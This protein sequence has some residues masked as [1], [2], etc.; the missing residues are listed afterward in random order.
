MEKKSR[1]VPPGLSY[2]ADN[3]INKHNIL[4]ASKEEGSRW[5]KGL[6][7]PKQAETVFFAGCGYQYTSDLEAMMGLIRKM[8]KTAIGSDLP[9]RVAGLQKK[10]DLAGVFRKVAAHGGEEDAAPLISAVKALDGFNIKFGYLAEEE[11]C[12]GAALYST[13]MQK[14]FARNAQ[15]SYKKLKAMGVKKIIGIVP[16]C[17]Y[18]LRSLFPLFI[19]GFDIEVKHF[20]EVIAEKL[21]SRELR[22]KENIKITYHDPCQLGR[23]LGLTEEPRRILRAI[24]GAEYIEPDWTKGDFSTCCGGGGGFEAVFPELSE[25]LAGNRAREL[26]DTGAQVIATHCPGCVMQ[27]KDGLKSLSVNNVKVMDLAQIVAMAME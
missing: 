11:P 26:A 7:L 27:I 15:E 8:D 4:G 19:Q 17:T 2:I 6:N 9:M 20:A 1:L 18:A 25:I 21:G 24:K 14:E 10:V 13:G 5:A 23:Y 12:C 22:L 16:S 3:I